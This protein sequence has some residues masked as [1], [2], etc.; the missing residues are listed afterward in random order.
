MACEGLIA[1]LD[2]SDNVE[3]G[4][5]ERA[6]GT[7]ICRGRISDDRIHVI[8]SENVV[9]S[10]LPDHRGS[11]PATRHLDFSDREIDSSRLFVRAQLSGMLWKITPAIP[12]N[13]ADRSALALYEVDVSWLAPVNGRTVMSLEARQIRAL[14]PPDRNVRSDE[15]LL[16]Q[17]EVRT[18]KLAE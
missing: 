1:K 14:I 2:R 18:H 17:R 4:L 7:R 8:V 10:E 12:L 9:R 15:P 16:E 11:E 3:A 5:S 6:N 13:P